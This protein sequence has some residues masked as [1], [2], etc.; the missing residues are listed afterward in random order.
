VTNLSTAA[1]GHAEP[2][3]PVLRLVNG[4]HEIAPMKRDQAIWARA[5]FDY[6][7]WMAAASLS[8]NTMYLRTY[9]LRRLGE[10][11]KKDPWSVT[12]DD[13]AGWFAA[14]GW[15]PG[16]VRSWRSMVSS[17][18][19][20]AVVTGRVATSPAATL[21]RAPM[22]RLRARPA[23]ADVVEQ[24]LATADLRLEL[25]ILLGRH[26]GLRR[27]EIA[28]SHTNDL[29]LDSD[30][31]WLTAHG[32]GGKDRD[33][34][35]DDFVVAVLRRWMNGYEG[36]LFPGAIEGHLAPASVGR[37][38]SRHLLGPW[39]AHTLRHRYATEV[40]NGSH[41][42]LS[43][44]KLLGHAKPETTQIYIEIDRSSLR[45]AASWGQSELSTARIVESAPVEDRPVESGSVAA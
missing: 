31:W 15:A 41:D 36:Y 17:F 45:R 28:R 4:A 14:Q 26:A 13:L 30:G 23:P 11:I 21:P 10:E 22:V 6:R 5:I 7:T 18:Y 8:K 38:V 34:P 35:L 29:W 44:Q 43:T 2:G 1:V 37:L 27:G 33:V 9:Q 42:L 20:W 32:K 19:K 24:A 40:W 25:M 3:A 39:T 16:T 12:T